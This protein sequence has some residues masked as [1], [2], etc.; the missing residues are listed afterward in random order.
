[1]AL[2]P[3]EGGWCQFWPKPGLFP[4]E[5]AIKLT[6][7]KQQ[8]AS[9]RAAKAMPTSAS[10]ENEQKQQTSVSLVSL[11]PAG[12]QPQFFP[13]NPKSCWV[14]TQA[15][16]RSQTAMKKKKKHSGKANCPSDNEEIQNYCLAKGKNED[17]SVT[18]V[19]KIN[20]VC[21]S[22]VRCLFVCDF[23]FILKYSE[24]PS[25]STHCSVPSSTNTDSLGESQRNLFYCQTSH[26]H[27]L[28]P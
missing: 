28:S 10:L 5:A 24:L 3:K 9:T 23:Y 13:F 8:S 27:T 22:K 15:L 21:V 16:S 12:K 7:T 1:M 4:G 26:P 6:S 18:F 17:R 25:V 19:R 14:D 20:E 2:C 11:P